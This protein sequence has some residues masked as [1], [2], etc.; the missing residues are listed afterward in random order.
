MRSPRLLAS[1]LASVAMLAAAPAAGADPVVGI[2]ENHPQVF[3]DPLF[4]DLGV[5]HAR[6]VTSYDVMTSGDDELD[7]VTR[8]LHAARAA[9][10][11][12]LV[13]FEHE[14]GDARICSTRRAQRREAV[15]ALPSVKAYER[16][17]RRFLTAFPFV[18]LI[19]PWN[20]V[21][22]VTQG[23]ARNPKRAAQYTETVR[24]ICA[25]CKVIDVDVLDEADR[26]TAKKP[27]FRHTLK[28]IK[29]FRKALKRRPALC[30]LHNYS[31]VNRF[32]DAG[33]KEILAALNCKQV[34]LTE[35][36]GLYDF[37]SF[38]TP[39]TMKGCRTSEACQ[40]KAIRYLFKLTR[41]YKAIKRVYVYSWFGGDNPNFDSGIV[42]HGTPRPAYFELRKHI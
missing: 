21:N 15:C 24:R 3:T 41:R 34:Y 42:A 18:K 4:T 30:G 28:W 6:L 40:V 14:R 36:G 39:A 10:V 32:R 5:R 26:V 38:W 29:D 16:S 31:A 23:T 22:H 1:L 7:R 13:T 11:E 12:V 8:Y 9:G 35:T 17:V 2:S 27:T 25:T 33:T 19:S 37:A 20:E